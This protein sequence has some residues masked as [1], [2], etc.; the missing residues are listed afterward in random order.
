MPQLERRRIIQCLLAL[1]AVLAYARPL[2]AGG[3]DG[4]TPFHRGIAIS[5]ALEW[6]QIEPGPERAFVFPPFAAP[7]NALTVDELQTLRR[8]GFDFVRL[9]VDPGPFLQ[10]E[11]TRRDKL[12]RILIDRVNRILSSGLAVVVDLHPSDMHPDYTAQALTAGLNAPVFRA[13]LRL[14]ERTAGLLAKLHTDRVALELMNE[15]PVPPDTW[16]PMLEAAYA[17]ARHG[18]SND[19][20]SNDGSSNLALVFDGGDESSAAGLMGMRT[21]PFAND[22]KVTFSFHYYDPYQFTHQGASWNAAR[23]LADVPYPAGARPLQVSLSATA[24]KISQS[25]LAQPKKSLTEIDADRRLISYRGSGFDAHT[26]AARF[27]QIAAWARS[28]GLP[29][30]RVM[31]GEFGAIDGARPS[32]RAQWF[33]DVRQQAERNGFGWAVWTYREGSFALTR[34]QSSIEIEPA[35]AQ[36]L[37]LRPPHPGIRPLP[38]G[39]SSGPR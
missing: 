9:A 35:I 7:S 27:A 8:T 32:E 11:G 13:Y 20:S 25:D 6:A 19:G 33:H 22:A 12:D 23:Y 14:V 21:S 16:Q 38:A 18:L 30:G 36:A 2:H 29:P 17:A 10:F 34:D 15:P 4:A 24:A 5:N 1:L 31:L 28:Q 26:I 3:L 39:I 37:D